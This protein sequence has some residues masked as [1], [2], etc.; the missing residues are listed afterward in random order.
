MTLIRQGKFRERANRQR[1]YQ[2][3]ENQQAQL[4]DY[5]YSTRSPRPQH[6]HD[7]T[8]PTSANTP[9]HHQEK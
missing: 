8:S 3:S 5:L 9:N 1:Q 2:Q 7:D 6:T 4:V